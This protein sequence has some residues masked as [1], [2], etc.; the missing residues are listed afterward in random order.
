MFFVRPSKYRHVF[1]TPSKRDLC[2]DSIRVSRNAW[3]TNLVKANPLFV[4]INLEAS[5]GISY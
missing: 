5:G 3:D 2:Y 4:S 1:G